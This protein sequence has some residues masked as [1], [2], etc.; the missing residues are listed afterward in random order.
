MNPKREIRAARLLTGAVFGR[1]SLA[2]PAEAATINA[3]ATQLEAV[4]E[5]PDG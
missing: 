5:T 2:P 4:P 1:A 3:V